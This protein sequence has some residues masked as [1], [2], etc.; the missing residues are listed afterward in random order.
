MPVSGQ[1]LDQPGEQGTRDVSPAM[2]C[3][4]VPSSKRAV[5]LLTGRPLLMEHPRVVLVQAKVGFI[6]ALLLVEEQ[7]AARGV[8]RA[9]ATI[10]LAS[11][12]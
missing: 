5:I 7:H 8:K 6:N 2:G 3:Q 12:A 4:V 10:I 1:S 9:P 11:L